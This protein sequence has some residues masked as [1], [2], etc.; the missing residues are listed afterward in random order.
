MGKD[1]LFKV[2]AKELKWGISQGGHVVHLTDDANP[3]E[4]IEINEN[5]VSDNGHEISVPSLYN[6]VSDTATRLFFT[7]LAQQ[8]E[9]D[10]ENPLTDNGFKKVLVGIKD[11]ITADSRE[12]QQSSI[13]SLKKDMD[14]YEEALKKRLQTEE[15]KKKE[16][17]ERR[18]F[19]L[20]CYSVVLPQ[21]F[22]GSL[23]IPLV[24]VNVQRMERA[25]RVYSEKRRAGRILNKDRLQAYKYAS[26]TG[27][28]VFENAEEE[29]DLKG[30][31]HKFEDPGNTWLG[32][33]AM[34]I[35]TDDV[36]FPHE[37]SP[38]DVKQGYGV[39]DCFMLSALISLADKHPEKIREAMSDNGDGTVTVRF[40]KKDRT[41]EEKKAVYITV[42]KSVNKTLGGTN[43]YSSSSLWVQMTEKAYVGFMALSASREE[44]SYSSIDRGHTGDFMNAFD[45]DGTYTV[46]SAAIRPYGVDCSLNDDG[47]IAREYDIFKGESVL[48]EGRKDYLEQEQRLFNFL[49][50]RVDEKGEVLTVGAN[51]FGLPQAPE[52]RSLLHRYGIRDGHAYAV[53]G[54]FEQADNN[55]KIRKFIKLRDPYAMFSCHYDSEF[56]LRNDGSMSMVTGSLNAGNDNMGTFCLELKDFNHFFNSFSGMTVEAAEEFQ[57]EYVDYAIKGDRKPEEENIINTEASEKRPE[58]NNAGGPDGKGEKFPERAAG[59]V[60]G[61]KAEVK[62]PEGWEDVDE[63]TSGRKAEKKAE[64]KASEGWE[65]VDEVIPEKVI[66]GKKPVGKKKVSDEWFDPEQE[67]AEEKE[68]QVQ[69]TPE[70]P[71]VKTVLKESSLNASKMYEKAR[72]FLKNKNAVKMGQIVDGNYY[73]SEKFTNLAAALNSARYTGFGGLYSSFS[74]SPEMKAVKDALNTVRTNMKN[75]MKPG[76]AKTVLE[77]LEMVTEAYLTNPKKAHNNRWRAVGAIDRFAKAELHTLEAVETN[78]PLNVCVDDILTKLDRMYGHFADEGVNAADF[79]MIGGKNLRAL[80]SDEVLKRNPDAMKKM[81]DEEAGII[82]GPDRE[83]M[84]R[85]VLKAMLEGKEVEFYGAVQS[86]ENGMANPDEAKNGDFKGKL[87]K[88]GMLNSLTKE[89]KEEMKGSLRESVKFEPGEKMSRQEMQLCKKR[90]VKAVYYKSVVMNA[91]YNDELHP[92]ATEKMGEGPDKQRSEKIKDKL[93]ELFAEVNP[94]DMD[95]LYGK[96]YEQVISLC[97]LL[98]KTGDDRDKLIAQS[99]KGMYAGNMELF[100]MGAGAIPADIDGAVLNILG[101]EGT[102]Q[103]YAEKMKVPGTKITDALN[104]EELGRCVYFADDMRGRLA[105]DPMGKLPDTGNVNQLM[106]MIKSGKTRQF[107]DAVVSGNLRKTRSIFAENG[108]PVLAPREN[109][110]KASGGRANSKPSGSK[111]A[112]AVRIE[113]KKLEV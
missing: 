94:D 26:D 47:K 1:K 107:Y 96:R 30:R 66:N 10:Y 79:V 110:G 81:S 70:N 82:Y 8:I 34:W 76:D 49:R 78:T 11:Y 72:E 22:D 87:E 105:D 97:D 31:F 44:G 9:K 113:E 20:G 112:E 60:T 36:L 95:S 71:V 91:F 74:D 46:P 33:P 32:K 3:D 109:R 38:T 90:T 50:K 52:R 65:D 83:L 43:T 37:P 111:K 28:T 29:L 58:E 98:E 2:A 61:K 21:H 88:P 48:A 40:F 103:L 5:S 42:N 51:F 4:F 35:K 17:D 106:S 108:K 19:L 57:K 89:E 14:E 41:D 12:K 18:L 100:D 53:L 102:R 55:G 7:E 80:L 59:N 68:V 16:E 67:L 77:R 84:G 45:G 101:A 93:D 75:G 27:W 39:E 24:M 69:K 85:I 92:A 104:L 6:N 15:D 64:V 73:F 63:I 56:R 86:D 54:T 99:I 25:K 13:R 23:V 62:A